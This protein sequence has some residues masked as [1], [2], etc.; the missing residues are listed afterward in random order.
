MPSNDEA[1]Q[2]KSVIAILNRINSDGWQS[3]FDLLQHEEPVLAGYALAASDL[4]SEKLRRSGLPLRAMLAIHT[5]MMT[6]QLVCIESM[7]QA[8]RELWKDFLPDA[9][10]EPK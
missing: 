5:E 3:R 6:A 9:E 2:H 8:S 7:R 1:V 10:A 4:L